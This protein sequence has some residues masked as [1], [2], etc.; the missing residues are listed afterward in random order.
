MLMRTALYTKQIRIGPND[1]AAYYKRGNACYNKG[2]YERAIADWE[3][4]LQ[5]D[6]NNTA[7]R[8][9]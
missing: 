9:N 5:I 7:T 6:P 2:D 8:R 3:R 4:A 1:V